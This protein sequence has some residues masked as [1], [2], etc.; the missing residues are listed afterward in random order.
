MAPVPN[1][2]LMKKGLRHG[3]LEPFHGHLCIDVPNL[4]LMKKGL[5]LEIAVGTNLIIRT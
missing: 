3:G 1:L 4:D 5:R 2:D